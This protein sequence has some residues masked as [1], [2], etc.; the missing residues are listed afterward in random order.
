MRWLLT[1]CLI[2]TLVA[3]GSG[4]DDSEPDT[5]PTPTAVAPTSTA[6]TLASPPAAIAA[7][8]A[9]AASPSAVETGQRGGIAPDS[10]AG[11]SEPTPTR[12][13]VTVVTTPR[14]IAKTPTPRVTFTQPTET[15]TVADDGFT[16]VVDESFDDPAAT[17]FFT[18]ES[19][20]GVIA[21]ID[22]GLYT[23]AVP[24]SAWQNIVAID[25]GDLGNAAILIE[26]GIQGDGAVGVVGRSVTN[27]DN[28]WTFY[29]C[30]LATD[31]RAGCHVSL[32]SEWI[33]LFTVEAGTVQVLEVNELFLS[34]VGDELA[35][36]IND[37]EIGVIN[38][39]SSVAGTWGVFAE[40]F[41]GTSVAWY[42]QITIATLAE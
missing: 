24:E 12:R 10:T 2:L 26:A 6:M 41:S 8:P 34:V 23:L 11:S 19:D 28:T 40:S 16:I 18:G 13:P 5:D 9:S 32:A 39:A 36:D 7:S 31:G 17:M 22:N 37:I 1:C 42:D 35:F 4:D 38:D 29:V 20:F 15:P 30:W 21:A 33:E 3:C 25:A 27:S 14:P